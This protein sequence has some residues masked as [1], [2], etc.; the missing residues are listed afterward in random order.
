MQ[1]YRSTAQI[2]SSASH[3]NDAASRGGVEMLNEL[4]KKLENEVRD[5][6]TRAKQEASAESPGVNCA[7][8]FVQFKSRSDAAAARNLQFFQDCEHFRM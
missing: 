7:A 5:L 8:G 2:A 6:R 3:L 1:V 4:V